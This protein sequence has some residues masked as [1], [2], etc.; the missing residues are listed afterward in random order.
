MR[1]QDQFDRWRVERKGGLDS[2]NIPYFELI[3]R[4]GKSD[5]KD[6]IRAAI[7]KDLLSKLPKNKQIV[8]VCA[9]GDTSNIVA[10]ILREERFEAMNLSGGMKAWGSFY[11]QK[12]LVRSNELSILQC[13]RLSRGCLSYVVS[14]KDE[15]VII[16]PF[17]NAAFYQDLF[18]SWPVKVRMIFDTHA[19]ADHISGARTLATHYQVPYFLHPYDGIHPMDMLPATFSYEPSWENRTYPLGKVKIQAIHIP[20]H[21][22]G[23]LAFLVDKRFLICGDSIFIHSLARPD[24]GGK[25]KA[26]TPLFYHSLQSL[27]QLPDDLLVL[28][29]HFGS[30]EESNDDYSFGKTLGELKRTNEELKLIQKPFQGF[31]QYVSERLPEFPPEYIDIKRV[32]LG[33]LNPSEEKAE[34]LEL[35]KNLCAIKRLP[36]SD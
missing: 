11:D 7:Q 21:T 12:W 10:E 32:N 17:R 29:A 15:A 19:H 25:A 20:G 3:E 4:G 26:W 31:D 23:S 28:P 33:L 8:V 30:L 2:L 13:I 9:K 22:L 24:L 34:E 6:S 14:S 16:D 1:S 36:R 27:L 5:F 35:G 18:A